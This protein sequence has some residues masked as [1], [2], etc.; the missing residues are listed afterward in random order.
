MQHAFR[1]CIFIIIQNKYWI[2]ENRY[3]Y[4]IFRRDNYYAHKYIESICN[5]MYMKKNLPLRLPFST[6]LKVLRQ[7]MMCPIEFLATPYIY[8]E[9]GDED[10]RGWRTKL[11]FLRARRHAGRTRY[12]VTDVF[13]IHLQI[14][15]LRVP[16]IRFRLSRT[17]LL[18]F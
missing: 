1:N 8:R 15:L 5:I 2:N 16:N 11:D 3:I 17:A 12:F 6:L 13:H 18:F 14:C 7:E 9:A 10:R 4:I